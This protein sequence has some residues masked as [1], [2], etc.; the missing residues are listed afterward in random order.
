[1]VAVNEGHHR[2]ADDQV[3]VCVNRVPELRS[4]I[5]DQ[6]CRHA[7]HRRRCH[8]R[9]AAA[10]PLAGLVPALAQAARTVGSPQ[11]RN[12][13][14][15]GGN[16]VTCS[17]AGDGLP[18]LAA[19]DATVEL[20]S[21]DGVRELPIGEF[22][23]GVKQTALRPGSCSPRSPC[24]CSTAGRAT[25][26]SASA[27]PWS[28]PSPGR[29]WQLTSRR[30]RCASPSD[31]LPRRS[32]GPPGRIL[33][34]RGSRLAGEVGRRGHSRRVRPPG[35]GGEQPDRRPSLDG[36]LPTTFHRGLGPPAAAPGVHGSGAEAVAWRDELSTTRLRVNGI[37]SRCRRRLA[38]GEPALRAARAPRAV[39][40][41][42][43]VRAGG[44]RLLQRAGR[45][46]VGVRV[47]RAGGERRRRADRDDR[48]SR[49][50]RASRPTSSRPS[51]T[52]APCSAGSAPRAW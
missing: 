42:G 22:M 11:I 2:V 48:G 50:R 6:R 41:Q 29:A 23:T 25:P 39:R 20:L 27:L 19:I 12:A 9:R 17:P 1:M 40:R 43:G 8:L 52:P 31:R 36:G 51:S 49:R 21:A 3:V 34:R 35:R 46:R 47:S 44:V 38:R 32:C 28:S 15:L 18:V 45:R 26:R 30:G 13:A 33:R 14:T 4:W 24:R 37:D 10:P 16:V 5:L 7:A